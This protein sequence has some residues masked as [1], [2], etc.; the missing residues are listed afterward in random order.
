MASNYYV[1]KSLRGTER[2]GQLT[3]QDV[4]NAPT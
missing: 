2:T 4:T 3:T 1:A